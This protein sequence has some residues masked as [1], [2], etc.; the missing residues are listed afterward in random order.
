MDA[1]A[2]LAGLGLVTTMASPLLA[3]WFT[4]RQGREARVRDLRIQ[5]YVD[6]G[7]YLEGAAKSLDAVTEYYPTSG[8]PGPKNL[9]HPTLLTA[10]VELLAA[11]SV[12]EAW[13][14]FVTAEDAISWEW[15]ENPDSNSEGHPY[16]PEDRPQVGTS[17]A[18]IE[19][20]RTALRSAIT[21][22]DSRR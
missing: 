6:V 4:H 19:A 10:R 20:L 17:R 8:S 11:K 12:R 15:S 2:V 21:N 22:P 3:S 1:T 18:S 13:R 9:V 16:I 7:E 14:S 5:L